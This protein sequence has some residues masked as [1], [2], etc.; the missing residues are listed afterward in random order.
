MLLLSNRHHEQDVRQIL[1]Q[2]ETLKH[3]QSGRLPIW[4]RSLLLSHVYSDKFSF[5]LAN[6]QVLSA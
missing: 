4:H 2:T 3:Y 5:G 1:G 6:I